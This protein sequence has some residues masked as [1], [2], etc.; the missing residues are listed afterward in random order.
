[1]NIKTIISL[2]LLSAAGLPASA[3][4]AIKEG[5]WQIRFTPRGVTYLHAGKPLVVDSKA[6]MRVDDTLYETTDYP[7]PQVHRETLA[8]GIGTGYRYVVEYKA[9][10]KLDLIQHYDFYKGQDYFLTEVNVQ[11]AKRVKCNYAAPI[12][13]ETA[14]SVL[15][16]DDSN[17]IM[18]YPYDNDKF[19]AVSTLPL[20][21]DT[22]SVEVTAFYNGQT[23]NGFVIG[24]VEH[25]AWKTGISYSARNSNELHR[26]ECFGGLAND[27][28]RDIN[29]D[30]KTTM[31][32]GSLQGTTVKSPRILVGAFADWRQ[33]M[34][35]FGLVNAAVAQPRSTNH[36][37]IFGWNS[38]GAMAS[39]VNFE[40]A[41]DVA[42]FIKS[43]LQPNSFENNGTAY[44]ILDAFWDF[45]GE[46]KIKEFVARCKAAGQTPGIYWCPWS[47]WSKNPGAYVEG[48][49]EQYRYCDI[50]LYDNSG[51]PIGIDGCYGVDPTHPATLQR[52]RRQ[53]QLFK[54]W[55][56]KYVKL[57]FMNAGAFEARSWYDKDVHTGMQAYNKGMAALSEACG[58]DLF[59][60]LSIAPVFPAQYANSR[61]IS[62]D[63][64]A[65][66]DNSNYVLNALSGFW[67]LDRVYNFNDPDHIVI[68]DCS[69][70]ENRMRVTSAAITGTFI[71]G[72]NL[73]L[74]GSY[75]GKEETRRKVKAV[76]TNSGINDIARHGRS[77]RPVENGQGSGKFGAESLFTATFGKDCYLAAFN[78]GD[79]EKE[80]AVALGRLGVKPTQI[81]EINE[82]WRQEKTERKGSTLS[83]SVAGKDVKVFHIRLK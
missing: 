56:F 71:I 36:A 24:S 57:D 32:H 29:D 50:W 72:D 62:C 12:L 4:K 15:P 45:M 80:F 75:P 65:D 47:D 17:R 21:K 76:M 20:D 10:G 51:K 53:M 81:V 67:W 41:V 13:S 6:R 11:A 54:D 77:F 33:G 73:S 38:W 83:F 7:R 14:V 64:W 42:S 2:T 27:Q 60:A 43:D 52:M 25:D 39:K 48:T 69:E 63:A 19:V 34:E 49:G 9:E 78:Y 26:L 55:G 8:D 40:G 18:V 28:T 5:Q 68:G 46:E 16:K 30:T 66:V 79:A 37:N 31:P 74:T 44:I 35:Q 22:C 59:M 70:G 58:D 23:R 1:M 82:L 61:R 3:Q